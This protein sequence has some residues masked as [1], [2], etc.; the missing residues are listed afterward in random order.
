MWS[1]VIPT[2]WRSTETPELIREL[3][4]SQYVSEI[5]IIDNKPS[6]AS[7]DL[8]HK[9]VRRLVQKRNV[10]VNPAWNQGVIES[11]NEHICICN[12]DILFDTGLFEKVFELF[13]KSKTDTILGA[14]QNCFFSTKKD[15][16]ITPGHWIGRG[17]GC[18]MFLRK[19]HWKPIP[20]ELK[21]FSGDKFIALQS[22]CPKSF[23]WPIKTKM[24][25]TSSRAEFDEIKNQDREFFKRT[26]SQ[27]ELYQLR[28]THGGAYGRLNL[29]T[30]LIFMVKEAAFKLKRRVQ[31]IRRK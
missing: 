9:K 25:T 22:K 28:I 18:L 8:S 7:C 4:D 20:N 3:C 24:S 27:L 21:I 11:M 10:Y 15:F 12:D 1:V 29:T 17:W 23:I 16:C 26:T 30:L 13:N 6:E 31:R 14:H 2:I 5:I 19:S